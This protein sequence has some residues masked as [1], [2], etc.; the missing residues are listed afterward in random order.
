MHR[1]LVCLSCDLGGGGKEVRSP[2]IDSQS[3]WP[4]RQ[5]YLTY[6]PAMLH[7]LTESIPWYKA[8]NYIA[9]IPEEIVIK[10]VYLAGQLI[11]FCKPDI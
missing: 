2:G 3:G 11:V 7:R 8:V 9:T 5:P 4:V 6:R 10:L 1:K